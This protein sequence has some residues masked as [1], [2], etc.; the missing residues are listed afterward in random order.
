M[1]H[2]AFHAPTV[3][4]RLLLGVAATALAAAG[5][6]CSE[7]QAST[8]ARWESLE[9]RGAYLVTVAGCNDCHTP[10]KLGANGPEPDMRRMLSGHPEDFNPDPP[11]ELPSGWLWAGT[12]TN[13][14]FAGPWGVSYATNLTPHEATGFGIYTEE[15]FVRALR[16]GRHMGTGRP[17]MPPMPWPAY[18]NMK[19]DD[20]RAIYTYL[21]TV[22]PVRNQVP[23]G[24]PAARGGGS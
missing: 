15:T 12:S 10:L 19:D 17:I 5:S 24:I 8:T 14:A 1:A 18:S 6:G 13:T 23:E 16:S 4:G 22:P 21:Q 2:N 3:A 20:L 11:G 7:G 9:E